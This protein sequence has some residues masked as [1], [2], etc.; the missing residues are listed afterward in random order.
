[1]TVPIKSPRKLIEVALP[2]DAI[3]VASAKEKSI[4]QGHPSALHLWWARRPLATARAV[5]FAQYVNDPGF[6]QG[7]GF[8]YGT[9]KKDASVQRQRLFRI[10]E[11][12]VKWENTENKALLEEARQEIRKSWLEVC[13]LNKDHPEAA[14][15]F[16][17]S[18]PPAVHDPFAGGGTIPIEAQRLGLPAMASD[19][20]PVAVLINKAAIEIP[21]RFADRSPVGP[22]PVGKQIP[23]AAS[24]W[25]GATG[26][27]EDVR[28]YGA[29]IRAEAE[30]RIG[31][32]YPPVEITADLA[33][34]R[35]DLAGLIGKPLTVVAWLWARTVRSPN[36]AFSHVEVP[37]ASSFVLSTKE[38]KEA[39]VEPR[40]RD[41][42]Y[43]FIVR[44]SL[45]PP[46]AADGTK[47]AG[48]GASFRCVMSGA[49]IGGDYIKA[50]AQAGRMGARLMAIVA[51]GQRRRVYL[52]PLRSHE[53][54]AATARPTW[55][56]DVEFFQQALGF[57]V[58]NYGMTKWSDV[59]TPRQLQA[60]VTYSDLVPLAQA[61]A[62]QDFVRAGGRDDD[63]PL[64]G[65]G[66]GSRAYGEAVG[67]YLALAVD[68]IVDDLTTIVTWRSSHGTGATRSTFARQALQMTWDYAEANALAGAG[69]IMSSIDA[70]ATAV[71]AWGGAAEG[72]AWQASAT[73]LVGH[74]ATIS[75]D[76]PYFDNIGYADLSDFFY[77][78]LRR[79]LRQTYPALFATIAV[80]KAEELVAT[81]ARHGGREQAE[82][83]FLSGMTDAMRQ[84]ALNAHPAL[85]VTIYYAFKQSETDAASD[86]SSTGWETFLEAVRAAGLA[87]TGTWPMRTEREARARGQDSNALASSI[88]LVCRR[89]AD[90]AATVSRRDFLRE[91]NAVLPDALDEMTKGAGDG[92]AP[93]A[94]ADLSQA[95]LGP[96]MAVFFK[97]AAVLEADGAP[98]SVQTAQ[99][100]INRFLAGDDFEPD[101]Q[102]CLSWFDEHGWDAAP[103]GRADVV[104]RAKGTSVAGLS[105][106][107]VVDS[108]SGKVRLLRPAE[109]PAEWRP[110]SDSRI[111]IWEILHHLIRTI[112][113]EGESGAARLLV[114]VRSKSE[115]VRQL[116][117]R[118][119]TLCERRG[120]A[121]DA[122][123]YNE[124]ITSWTAVEQATSEVPAST[125]QLGLKLDPK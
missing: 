99:K 109:Y 76:P 27:A 123:A 107:G 13:E 50:E 22:I 5:L 17:P 49:A 30:A 7:S 79:S 65:G 117:Y 121:E 72:T 102:F 91:L 60:L 51:E 114:D 52:S 15:L 58:G 10:I 37:L 95:I 66:V 98:M 4:R 59:F 88:V 16:D 19:L 8:K 44:T 111:A 24:S 104:A 25:P 120:M 74:K 75:T 57:R 69:D 71:A 48:R 73:D 68:G 55:A 116:A 12:L 36:P 67:V 70:V 94:P 92:Q 6:Q 106:A 1:V 96:G 18:R 86:T 11:E 40:L 29:W 110:A 78:W 119:Y 80:P 26:I 38:G 100:L 87:V 9:N 46:E 85:P 84:I 124:L 77:V 82:K 103:F 62:R 23:G 63:V 101:T 54:A 118:L 83:F 31:H 115:A 97:Y 34:G 14:V 125:R 122:R 93:V 105:H 2:L 113:S 43:D 39:W 33:A 112:R 21:P 81:P 56:P 32:L 35:P 90:D 41:D 42:G 47:A 45:P 3:N 53:D 20:N 89:R 108:R 61:R 28:R 64:E